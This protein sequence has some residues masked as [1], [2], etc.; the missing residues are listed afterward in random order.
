MCTKWNA[1][2]L[3]DEADVFLEERSLHELERNKLVSIFLRVLEYYE[4]KQPQSRVSQ[5]RK[6]T[7]E[8]GI[9]F[10]TTNR[11]K[12]FDEAFLSRIHVALHFQ[13]LSQESKEQV[14]SAFIKKADAAEAFTDEQIK[15]LA[16]RDI[17]GRQ[18]KNA[19]RTAHSLAVGRNEQVKF[20]HIV[21]TLDAM[22]EFNK[23]F[24]MGRA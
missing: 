9:M 15:T 10:L 21:Q 24:E 20:E 23:E 1:I 19:V 18:I 17:N 22:A 13:Q 8:L 16:E 6:L 3:L 4:G 7:I 2:L 5:G 12:S 11:V 14:W